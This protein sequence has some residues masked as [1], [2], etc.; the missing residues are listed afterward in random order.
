MLNFRTVN[1]TTILLLAGLCV[2]GYFFH[3]PIWS[4]IVVLGMWLA[5]IVLGSFFINY[6]FYIKSLLSNNNTPE[7]Q[8]SITFDDGPHPQFTPRVLELLQ[9]FD[10]RATFFC[11]GKH[12][13]TYPELFKKIIDDGH[14]VGN[15]TYSHSNYFGFFSAKRVVRELEKTNR[16]VKEQTGLNIM[17]YRPA[18]GVTNPHIAK[19]L[20][21]TGL[22]SVGWS[23]RSLDTTKLS[24]DAVLKRITTNLKK[25]D[26]ILLHDTSE[27]TITVLE[28]LLY[29]LQE[30][31][32]K[33]VTVDSIFKIKA[34][35]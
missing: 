31:D 23:K 4:Y 14:T 34:Y 6:N 12:I 11:T 3:I 7:N 27:K 28:R 16:I 5:S 20:K 8:V 30:R 15:H 22:R 19:A 2:A 25:G 17:L 33:S 24:A 10:A 32:I 35:A 13:E 26:I 1:I 29:F 9:Q 18:F 21:I